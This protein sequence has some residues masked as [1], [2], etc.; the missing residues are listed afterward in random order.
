MKLACLNID[1]VNVGLPGELQIRHYPESKMDFLTYQ[2]GRM[3]VRPE[4][5]PVF[6]ANHTVTHEIQ[7]N[8]IATMF[9]VMAWGSSLER[10]KDMFFSKSKKEEQK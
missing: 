3:G 6:G 10:A 8:K 1:P 5:Q 2:I 7:T 9:V 4:M